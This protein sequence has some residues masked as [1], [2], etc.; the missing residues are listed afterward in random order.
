MS[1]ENPLPAKP[2]QMEPAKVPSSVTSP[3][4]HTGWE[5]TKFVLKAIEVRMRF[6]A[7]LVGLGLVIAYWSTIQNYWDHW[8]RPSSVA[9][10]DSDTEYFCPM[11]PQVVRASLDPGGKI[12]NCP[13]C[14]MPLSKRKK[15]EKPTLPEGVLARVQLSPQRVTMAGVQ[16]AT[17][18]YRPLAGEIRTVG[19]VDYVHH[20]R[21]RS[22]ASRALQPRVVQQCSGIAHRQKVQRSGDAC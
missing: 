19:Y 13:I 7:V 22:A 14:G 12:P 6:I 20:G 15:G 16:T 1:S 2:D 3:A 5:R 11:H 21:R 8:T 4:S 10:A 9:A 17:V 18:D